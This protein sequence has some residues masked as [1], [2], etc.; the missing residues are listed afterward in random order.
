MGLLENKVALI[1]GGARGQGRAHAVT[2]ARE[3]ADVVVFDVPGQLSTVPYELATREDLRETAAL[4]EKEGRRAIAVVGDVRSQAD[5]DGAVALALEQFGKI[6]ILVANAGIWYTLDFWRLSE[7]EWDQT[8]GVNLGGVWR[9]AKAVAPGMIERQSGS[10]VL[11]ASINGLESGP[12]YAHYAASKHGVLGLMK[13]IAVELA[14]YGIRC[15]ALC[16]GPTRTPMTDHQAAWDLFA[17]YPGGTEADML[18]AGYNFLA[19]KGMNWLTPQ[20]QADAALFLNSDL[21]SSITGVALPVDA[22][23]LVLPGHNPA[24]VK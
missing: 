21:A 17:G 16:P 7:D 20:A 19:L 11:V 24:P 22:G 8:L 12:T 9:S 15:N 2:C 18:D 3:G 14:P 1:T 23:H 5:L 10:I 6:D 13:S 4:V